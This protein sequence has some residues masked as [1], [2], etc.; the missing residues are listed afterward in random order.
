MAAKRVK[1]EVAR[2]LIARPGTGTALLTQYSVVHCRSQGWPGSTG[3][4]ID[5]TSPLLCF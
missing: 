5:V 3:W 2:L 1:V 4:E